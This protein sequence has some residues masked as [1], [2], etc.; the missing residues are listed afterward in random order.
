MLIAINVIAV[1]GEEKCGNN[2]KIIDY[3][4]GKC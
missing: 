1:F 2:G 4:H 3:E